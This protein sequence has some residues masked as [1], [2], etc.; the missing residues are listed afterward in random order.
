MRIDVFS[1]FPGMVDGFCSESLLGR[2]RTSGHVD[3]RCH[4]IRD[5]TD[6]V[7]RKVD[8]STFGGGAGMLMRPEPIF[9][10]VEAAAP[11]RPLILLGP[12]GE[13][14]DQAMANTLAAGEGFSL[15]CGRY[16]GVDQR[17]RE[18]LV[19]HEVSVGDVV[20]AGGEVAACL[21]IEAVTRLL[22]GVMGNSESPLTESFASGGLLEEPQW[23]RPAEFRGWE[24]PEVLRGGDHARIAQW[25]RIQ[26]LRRT[27]LRRPD[28]IEARGGL[29]EAEKTALEGADPV[30]YP[31]FFAHGGPEGR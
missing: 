3:L 29:S 14:F 16:E 8:Y 19:D 21:V 10:A 31:S 15:L 20:L 12:G 18:H 25:R 28:L 24:V 7:H 5:H 4:D 1:I 2:A 23:T 22:P 27:V 30:S 13:P 26:A 9:A 17:V 6:D 11:P